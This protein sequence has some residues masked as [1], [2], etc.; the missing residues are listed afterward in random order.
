MLVCSSHIGVNFVRKVGRL[1]GSYGDWRARNASLWRGSGT[2]AKR[3]PWT[4]LLVSGSEGKTPEAEAYCLLEVQVL[5]KFVHFCYSV[6][7]FWKN[8]LHFFLESFYW[9]I[10]TKNGGPEAW[11]PWSLKSERLKPSSL[12]EVYAYGSSYIYRILFEVKKYGSILRCLP[13]SFTNF[14]SD[15]PLTCGIKQQRKCS[16]NYCIHFSHFD[17][18]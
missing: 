10:V 6:C 17:Q 2:E 12:I 16:L 18:R 5:C 7:I 3:G 8:L 13:F 15:I 9:Y 1:N 4:E 14:L 11:K